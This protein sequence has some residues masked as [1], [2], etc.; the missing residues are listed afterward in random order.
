MIALLI[1]FAAAAQQPT[2]TQLLNEAERAAQRG[3][4][5]TARRKLDEAKPLIDR[6][7]EALR[8]RLAAHELWDEC[9]KRN[10]SR[11]ASQNE[12]AD[13]LADAVL[14]I[15]LESETTVRT[16][17]TDVDRDVQ[18]LEGAALNDE[19]DKDMARWRDIQRRTALGIIVTARSK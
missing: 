18:N 16:R 4:E 9:V 2:A 1:L 13:V 15:C 19:V 3:D 12:K 5:V 17:Q 11:V 14:G 7:T 10:A 8:S 6:Q